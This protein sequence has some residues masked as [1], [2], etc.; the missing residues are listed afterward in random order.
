MIMQETEFQDP[1]SWRG[2]DLRHPEAW[3]HTLNDDHIGE[4]RLAVAET[5]NDGVEIVDITRDTFALPILGEDLARFYQEV[6]FGRGFVVCDGLPVDELNREEV[7]RAWV[8]IGTHLGEPVSQNGKGHII[9]HVKD[10]GQ[11]P[12]SKNRRTFSTSARQPYHTDSC[13]IVGLLCLRA[14]KSGGL[15][16][17]TSSIAV[18][19]EMLERRPDLARIL[20]Q[21]F[22][23]DRRGEVPAGMQDTFEMAAFYHHEGRLL[24]FMDR[25]F[26]N[27]AQTH[28]YVPRLTVEEIAALDLLEAIA[29]EDG[30]YLD[31][32]WHPGSFVFAHNHQ[33][34]HSRTAYEDFD[35]PAQR[36]HLLRLWLSARTGWQ[37]PTDFAARYG[38]IAVGKKRGGIV[39]P[40]MQFTAPLEAE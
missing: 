24:S 9:G 40:G 22:I 10:L 29:A 35:E 30:M 36:R 2:D 15:F 23:N 13:D 11:G 28:D 1:A 18:Y 32:E 6:V 17:L 20:T 38:E 25:N 12:A 5:I 26:I 39:V 7:I 16:S 3:R 27:A 19:N 14:A 34:F 37:L 8:G 4:I 31:L 33:V 21:P